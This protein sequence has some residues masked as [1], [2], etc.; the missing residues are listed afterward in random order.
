[1]YMF[2]PMIALDPVPQPEIRSRVVAPMIAL[3]PLPDVL[4]VCPVGGLL[5]LLVHL[6]RV[7]WRCC[8]P[9]SLLIACS[10]LPTL[11]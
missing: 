7:S 5:L 4:S 1:M 2:V 10:P 11:L 8:L 9:S 3:D 6:R